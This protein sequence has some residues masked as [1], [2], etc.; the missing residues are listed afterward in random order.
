MV[1]ANRLNAD[2]QKA[3][4]N[5]DLERASTLQ[6]DARTVALQALSEGTLWGSTYKALKNG[7]YALRSLAADD[8]LDLATTLE[9]AAVALKDKP[10]WSWFAF[11]LSHDAEFALKCAIKRD[12]PKAA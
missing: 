11:E 6:V 12:Q 1:Y 9:L 4:A 2:S 10:E 3:A 8:V 7:R 5:R